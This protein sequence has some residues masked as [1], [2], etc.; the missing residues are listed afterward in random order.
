MTL[1]NLILS[2]CGEGVTKYTCTQ[3][4]IIGKQGVFGAQALFWYNVSGPHCHM[5]K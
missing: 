5:S 2:L 4:G 3:Q 1:T